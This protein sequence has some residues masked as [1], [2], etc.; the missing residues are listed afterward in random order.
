MCKG[1]NSNDNSNNGENGADSA[2]ETIL[3]LVQSWHLVAGWKHNVCNTD[4][5]HVGLHSM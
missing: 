4:S 3:C 2:L 1:D 5:V